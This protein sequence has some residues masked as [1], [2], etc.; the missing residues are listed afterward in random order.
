MLPEPCGVAPA[1]P[2]R[3]PHPDDAWRAVLERDP[4]SDGAFVYAVTTTGVYCRPICP[5]RRPRRSNVRFFHAAVAAEEAG[6]RACR[7]CR[8]DAPAEVPALALVR[9]VIHHLESTPEE[10]ITLAALGK[11]VH[12]SP[13]HLQRTF[14]RIV[15]V[16]PRQY[17]E[18]LRADRLRRT[19]RS[20]RTVSAA[21]YGAGYGSSSRLYD[22]G[23]ASLGMVPARYAA[24][25]PGISVEC[26]IITTRLGILLI[27]FTPEGVSLVLLGDSADA[28]LAEAR[29]EL[30]NADLR[31]CDAPD[32]RW[33]REVVASIE[34]D[35]DVSPALPVAMRGTP[36]R[37]T[38]W[39]AL[40]KI[41]RG[42]TRTYSEIAA[43]IGSPGA[44]RAVARACAAN[45]LAVI[46][47]CH[48]VVRRG[49]ELAGYRWGLERKRKLLEGEIAHSGT[50]GE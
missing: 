18:G 44:A 1:T 6:F 16:S 35:R 47:P 11:L 30:P 5:A 49:G 15:G 46:V 13:H 12:A 42:S 28:V 20:A 3:A 48:R 8:P 7:R 9:R 2:T 32:H 40:R 10:R 25:G 39:Q 29:R 33:V 31:M 23:R 37:F 4:A 36:F 19:L 41:P 22:A 27:G 24:G 38:V 14:K 21:G 17:Q 34:E 45:H 26:S 50:G 43:L